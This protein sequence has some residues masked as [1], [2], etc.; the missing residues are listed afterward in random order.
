MHIGFSVAH[1]EA[2]ERH[3]RD[4]LQ[5]TEP[6]L[7]SNDSDEAL[8][9]RDKLPYTCDP[10]LFTTPHP[11]LSTGIDLRLS[12]TRLTAL[13]KLDNSKF[14]SHK[15]AS[16]KVKSGSNE[17]LF[18]DMNPHFSKKLGPELGSKF[19]ML[20]SGYASTV[21][22][23][24]AV[25]GG[26]ATLVAAVRKLCGQCQAGVRSANGVKG[27]GVID[28]KTV[29]D[30]LSNDE[31]PD[32]ALIF[33]PVLSLAGFLPWH[34]RLTEMICM[35]DLHSTTPFEFRRAMLRFSQ[36]VHRYGK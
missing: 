21:Y 31:E 32:V 34:T 13:N 24:D 28:E 26:R 14:S 29:N 9:A 6:E 19:P 17:A 36:C 27:D 12:D 10:L 22:F 33:G 4:M 15:R 35:R 20:R 25:S 1:Q 18:G 16:N 3:V 23:L 8:D 7:K 30:A 11:A 2:I 5:R